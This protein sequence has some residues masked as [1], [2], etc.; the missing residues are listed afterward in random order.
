MPQDK[1]LVVDDEAIVRE[2]IRDWLKMSEYDVSTAES[3]EEALAM[4]EKQDFNVMVLDI[5]LPG[6]SGLDVLARVKSIRPKLKSIIITAYPTED[7]IVEAKKLGAIDYLIKP[8]V[9]EDLERLI[10]ETIDS[11]SRD[12]I[13]EESQAV[14]KAAPE[15]E[16][17]PVFKLYSITGGGLKSLVEGL[18]KE[19]EVIGVKAKQGK[20]IFDTI[21]N[22]D[23]LKLDY[24]VTLLPPSKFLFPAKETL[25]KF[26]VEN[27][28]QFHAV[29]DTQPRVLFGV[30]P[31]DINAI[32]LLDD[33]FI[34]IN[35][36]PNYITRRQNTL[37][38]GI[39]CLHPASEAFAPSMGTNIADSG[40]DLLLTDIGIGYVVTVGT[41]KGAEVLTKYANPRE[42]TGEEIA[43]QKQIRDESV[44]RYQHSL[45]VPK[46][47]L[48][49]L[50][51]DNYE[52]PYWEFRAK[53]CLSCGSCVMV[54]PTCFCF[55]VKDE[56]ALN[57]IEGE[58]YRSWDGCVL[59]DFAKVASGENFRHTKG[60][61]FRHRILRK[62]KYI[63]EKYG[64]AG[65][66][67]CGRC[68]TACLAKIASP[69]EA[70]NAITESERVKEEANQ[71]IHEA[72]LN[73]N[74]YLPHLALLLGVKDLGE[75]E[76]VFDFK[77]VDGKA[78]GHRPGQFVEISIPGI[79]ESP[80]SISSSP[81]RG[82]EFQLAIRNA[83]SV[84][85]ALHKLK[86]GQVV[87]IR[88]P[89]GNGFST[90][91]LKGKDI[92]LIA[93][94]IGLFPLR[95]LIQY[96]M[97]KREN[98]GRVM[99]LIGARSPAERMFTEELDQWRRTPSIEY[100]ETVDKGDEKWSGNVGVITT[101]IPKVRIDPKN[102]VA[103]VVGP[104]VMYRFV[105]NE[106]K[107]IGLAD[108]NIVLS[109]ERRMKCGVGK[110]GHCQINGVYVCQE[111]PVF[112]LEQ[113]R[114]LREAVL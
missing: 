109:L 99:L 86:E 67:G 85:N 100:M 56:M 62:G 36:D 49:K 58:R 14:K 68:A 74:I 83:G 39:D 47:R 50:L 8:L 33:V 48:L 12:R 46:E 5:R 17:P 106:L 27:G 114:G 26:N 96:V 35:P 2:S 40:F 57:L 93:G 52:N 59:V 65:C 92:L 19:R 72:E 28:P 110:C 54:C 107:K 90:E 66:V 16:I 29:V 55:D 94:G 70:F 73:H 41:K 108:E 7:T 89:F 37:I 111:G 13:A 63:L 105:I 78:L 22:F 91:I 1:I 80:I 101:L 98:F 6:E 10:R 103:V 61:R 18:L 53:S 31:D 87:G 97:D 79:G 60:S 24:D 15:E 77:F 25:L 104:P 11:V 34:R 45:N 20:F 3:G 32:Q 76:K 64:R 84:T 30:H 69:V 9:P 71:I 112:T 44:T 102:T 4:I 21:S 43:R 23:Q 82:E 113:L 42:V 88:G 75:K 51:Q 95:S 81:T 38:I